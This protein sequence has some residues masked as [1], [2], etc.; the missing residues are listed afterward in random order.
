MYSGVRYSSKGYFVRS[1]VFRIQTP[2]EY[3][4]EFL[5]P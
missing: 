5:P 4:C 2:F 3:L 1:G